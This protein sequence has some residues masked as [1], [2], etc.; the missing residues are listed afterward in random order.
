ME[1]SDIL[2]YKTSLPTVFNSVYTKQLC[3]SF[4]N[5]MAELQY[6]FHSGFFTVLV[7]SLLPSLSLSVY[8]SV[9]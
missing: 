9:N 1:D 2:N 6:A 3:L 4:A 5:M 7:A 8:P